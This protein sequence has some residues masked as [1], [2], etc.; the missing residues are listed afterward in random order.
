MKRVCVGGLIALAGAGFSLSAETT[1]HQFTGESRIFG[2]V[3]VRAAV[4]DDLNG[5]DSETCFRAETPELARKLAAKRLADMLGF[6]DL[7]EAE[8]S[9]LGG[10]MLTLKNAGVWL[11]GT[12]G[13]DFYEFYAADAEKLKKLVGSRKLEPVAPRSYPRYWDC[14]DNAGPALWVGG[15]GRQYVLPEDFEWLKERRMAFCTLSPTQSRLVAPGV[16]DESIFDWHSAM[17]KKYDLAYRQLLFPAKFEWSWNIQPLPYNL[18]MKGYI[19]NPWLWYQ[20]DSVTGGEDPIPPSENYRWDMRGHLARTLGR[21]DENLAGWH[22]CTEIPSASIQ[23]LTSLAGNPGIQKMWVK[24]LTDDLKLDLKSAGLRYRNDAKA[25][26][27][28]ADFPMPTTLDFVGYKPGK[29][30]VLDDA[31]WETHPDV[32]NVGTKEEWFRTA[33]APKDWVEARCNDPMI[34]MYF[35]S[36]GQRDKRARFWMRRKINVTAEQLKDL[37]YLHMASSSYHGTTSSTFEVWVN[38]KPLKALTGERGNYSLCHAVGDTLK[39]GENEIVMQTHGQPVAGYIFLGDTPLRKYPAMSRAENQLWY[40]GVNFSASLRLRKIEDDL[41]AIR[42]YDPI[43]PMKLMATINLLDLT[44]PLSIKYGAYQHDTGGAGGY[45]APMTGARLARSHGLPWSCEQGGPPKDAAVFQRNITFYLMY[46]ND[47]ADLVFGVGHYS[48]NPSVAKWFDEN[49]ELIHCLGKMHLPMPSIGVLRSSRATRMGFSEPWNWDIARGT[50]QGIGRNFVYLETPDLQDG[51][52][53]R[54]PVVFDAGT[55]L[56]T[57]EDI[58]GLSK[59]VEQGGVF[60]AQ[61]HTGRHLPDQADAWPLAAALKLSVTPRLMN[62]DN[63]H[64]WPIEKIVF[65]DSQNLIRSLRGKSIEGS[66]VAIDHLDKAHTGA[67]SI[68]GGDNMT[69]VARWADGSIAVAEVKHGKGRFILLGSPFFSRMKDTNGVWANDERRGE[70]L[71]ELL[72]GLSVP[73]DSKTDDRMTWAEAWRSKNGVYDFYPVARMVTKEGEPEKSVNVTIR[74]AAP[75]T[76]VVEV[77]AK[78]HPVVPVKWS[79]ALGG[80]ELPAANY[81]PMKSRVF[82]AP[83]ADMG[84]AAMD[85]FRVQTDLWRTVPEVPAK[86]RPAPLKPLANILPLAEGWQCSSNPALET[87]FFTPDFKADS[88]WKSVKLGTFAA[89]GLPEKGFALFRKEIAIPANWKGTKISLTFD[90]EHWFWGL[91]PVSRLWINGEPA[92]LT[93]PILPSSVPSF[94]LDVTKQAASGK[95]I[96]ALAIDS[97]NQ[98]QA[99]KAGEEAI[100]VKPYGVSGLFYLRSDAPPVKVEP[101]A[102]PWF[103]ALDFQRF[104][105]VKVGDKAKYVYLE[106]R[107]T[108]PAQWPGKRLFL[109]ADEHLG[110]L[111]LNDQVIATPGW[112]RELDVSNLVLRDGENVLRWTPGTAG[113]PIYI[114]TSNRAVP[115]MQFL[116]LK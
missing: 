104:T 72:K 115:A 8:G 33:K 102:T 55:V 25:F 94:T 101:V 12:Q 16:V 35:P 81:G 84:N 27:S 68:K 77:S 82:I 88:T 87:A 31:S 42:A 1:K 52:I 62:E 50:L 2:K 110:W 78:G 90:A 106:T 70:L 20:K 113:D 21:T 66:G 36:Q 64:K 7:K 74:R 5:P 107:F 95:I 9:V 93:Q 89:M 60:I 56:M 37:K 54:F 17:A 98:P 39:V 111:V 45:W 48:R 67:V 13:R 61:H 96:L 22:G 108:L 18:P 15:G 28:W 3:E 59:Y 49:I 91:V 85:W 40:D 114:R 44:T 97:R 105:P 6:G 63:H 24:Y 46:G 71:D 83:R 14:F 34:M 51:L 112:M 19:A 103:A 58:A 79:K 38:E 75:L 109:S 100:Q 80:F 69:P 92:A 26:R 29:S 23:H 43:R 116:W 86:L 99:K 47:A 73:Q 10:T 11:L 41:I 53:N 4:N 32:G 76:E 30:M 57:Q 65:T